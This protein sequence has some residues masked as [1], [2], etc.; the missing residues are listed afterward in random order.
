MIQLEPRHKAI[1]D[2]ILKAHLPGRQVY[3]FGSRAKGK[4]G[5]F[6]DL[7]LYIEGSL[8]RLTR[9]VLEEAFS[10]SDLPTF[11]DIVDEASTDAQFKALIEPDKQKW[12]FDS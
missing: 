8:D 7:D 3:V 1:V 11:V 6:S 4:A 2:Q 10:E 9:S 5:R 12:V